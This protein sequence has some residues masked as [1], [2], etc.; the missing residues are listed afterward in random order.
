MPHSFLNMVYS[1]KV[2]DLCKAYSSML[3]HLPAQV[4]G[5]MVMHGPGA[6][7]C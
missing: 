4:T 7:S 3:F 2:G 6:D 5:G 1:N